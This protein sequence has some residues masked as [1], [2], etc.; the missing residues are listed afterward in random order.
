MVAKISISINIY[1]SHILDYRFIVVYLFLSNVL[2]FSTY[3]SPMMLDIFLSFLSFMYE[4]LVRVDTS[5][6]L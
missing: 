4:T 6:T 3:I 1:F 2:Q 5:N